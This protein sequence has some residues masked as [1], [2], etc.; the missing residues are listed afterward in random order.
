MHPCVLEELEYRLEREKKRKKIVRTVKGNRCFA[1]VSLLICWLLNKSMNI[2][3]P[4]SFCLGMIG[5]PEVDCH[6][7]PLEVNS[8]YTGSIWERIKPLSSLLHY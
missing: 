1:G 4:K 7:N 6:C 5:T 8:G 2:K 3:S